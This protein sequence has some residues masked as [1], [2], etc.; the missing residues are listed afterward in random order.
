MFAFV[1]SQ[2]YVNAHIL[3]YVAK[4]IKLRTF[5]PLMVA[6]FANLCSLLAEKIEKISFTLMVLEGGKGEGGGG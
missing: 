5:R 3:T 1:I 2:K 4:Q 6:G